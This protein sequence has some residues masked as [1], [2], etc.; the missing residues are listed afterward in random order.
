MN[1]KTEYRFEVCSLDNSIPCRVILF[2][3]PGLYCY[4]KSHVHSSIEINYVINGSM[5]I[6]K[7]SE[8]VTLTDNE[9]TV[10]NSEVPH[11]SLCNDENSILSYLVL[12]FSEKYMKSYFPNY[13]DYM[14]NPDLN[15]EAKEEIRNCLQKIV[16]IIETQEKFIDLSISILT[17]RI[18]ELLFLNCCSLRVRPIK[19]KKTPLSNI[20]FEAEAYVREHYTEKMSLSDISKHVGL[21]PQNFAKYFKEETGSTFY[22]YLNYTRLRQTLID[23]KVNN[24]TQTEA[25]LNNGFPNVKSFISVFKKHFGCTLSEYKKTHGFIPLLPEPDTN[26]SVYGDYIE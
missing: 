17:A 24:C 6:V 23:V 9:Y 16:H 5:N 10:I 14:F 11:G 13:N 19:N 22:D 21:T 1:S 8:T 25:A 15:L 20:S 26:K 18:L 7:K 2:K 3:K 12:I 4:T